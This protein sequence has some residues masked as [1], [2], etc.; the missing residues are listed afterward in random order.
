[1][2]VNWLIFCKADVIFRC[3]LGQSRTKSEESN[4]RPIIA[5]L[6]ATS[7]VWEGKRFVTIKRR[8]GE[9]F[10]N[11]PIGC[12]VLRFRNQWEELGM[13]PWLHNVIRRIRNKLH[14]YHTR[15]SDI[16]KISLWALG[17]DACVMIAL[18]WKVEKM[19]SRYWDTCFPPLWTAR[20]S[21]HSMVASLCD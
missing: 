3:F 9:I 8:L 16:P 21:L 10:G 15:V 18:K 13:I 1:M 11:S 17:T 7:E 5:L 19:A 20:D 6:Q 4:L 2:Q 14:E 12:L